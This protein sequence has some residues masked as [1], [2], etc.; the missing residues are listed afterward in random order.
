MTDAYHHGDLRQALLDAAVRLIA[1]HGV[2]GLSLR[3]AAREVGVSHAAPYRH[4]ADK[5]ALLMAIAV[6][7][8]DLLVQAAESAMAGHTDSRARLNAYGVAYVRFAVERPVYFRVMFA[9]RLTETPPE[10]L[11]HE[12][13]AFQLLLEA[14]QPVT[15]A[16]HD[17]ELSALSA[18]SWP[19]GL[20]TLILDG[21]VPPALVDT[22]EKVEALARR[23]VAQLDG[24]LSSDEG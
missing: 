10:S 17:P 18:W 23:V 13:R 24:A 2:T 19:H 6:Q 7:G 8:F 3:Q 16:A 4:F 14:V 5:S 22:P 20:A 11:P 1:A 15:G 21:R 9:E 12:S